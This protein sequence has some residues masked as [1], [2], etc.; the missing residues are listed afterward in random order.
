MGGKM[1]TTRGCTCTPHSTGGRTVQGRQT[2]PVPQSV[3]TP[4]QRGGGSGATVRRDPSCCRMPEGGKGAR[5]RQEDRVAHG[6]VLLTRVGTSPPSL[7][8]ALQSRSRMWL[9]YFQGAGIRFRTKCHP[10][11]VAKALKANPRFGSSS[12]EP[13]RT[14]LGP[15]SI[16]R[17]KDLKRERAGVLGRGS[18]LCDGGVDCRGWV[19][20]RGVAWP[21]GGR[22]TCPSSPCPG[23]ALLCNGCTPPEQDRTR[24][25]ASSHE[26]RFRDSDLRAVRAT[27][28]LAVRR[29]V[30]TR[31]GFV[32]NSFQ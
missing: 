11:T 30:H 19:S 17:S 32:R 1:H 16:L 10:E 13:P 23:S 29:F 31:L 5:E 18:W 22:L 6:R 3:R 2:P 20:T 27:R 8:P 9:W 12:V 24:P 26:P 21:G 15:S 4:G 28:R 25:A 7:T 14:T